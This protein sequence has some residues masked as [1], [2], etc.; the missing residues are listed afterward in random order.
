MSHNSINPSIN[1]H[2]FS[3]KLGKDQFEL[4]TKPGLPDWDLVCPSTQL[5]AEYAAVNPTD[6]VLLYGCHQGA[7]GAYLARNLLQGQLSITD[8]NYTALEITQQ[9]LSANNI[10]IESVNIL[11][12]IDLPQELFQYFHV[13]ILQI[14]KGRLLARRWLVQSYNALAS[15]GNLYIAGSNHAGIQSVIKDAQALFGTE[16]I[17]A[18][19][20]GNRIAR[21]IKNTGDGSLPDWAQSPGIDPNTWV[22]YSIPLSNHTFH[23]HSLPGVFSFDHLDEGTRMLLNVTHVPPGAKVLDVGC[24]YGIIGLV[25]AVQGA[26][27]VHMIDNNLLAIKSCHQNIALNHITNAEAIA[28]DLL[29]PIGSNTYDLILS[30]PPFHADHAVDY[31]IARAMI[32]QSFQALNPGGRMIIV[33]NRFI[34]YDHLINEIFGNISILTESGKFHVLSGLKSS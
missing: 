9:T 17:L 13:V 2:K 24:G 1:V 29:Y 5:L 20:K 16:R 15:G 26:S 6:S 27:L 19:K 8:T 7:L 23:I 18:Y 31:Q 25:A 33:A 3:V 21:L 10:P 34:R 22:E 11:T 30:N 4:V 12:D 28:G 32:K 14:P